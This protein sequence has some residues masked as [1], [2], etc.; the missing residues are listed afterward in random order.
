MAHPDEVSRR[1]AVAGAR[2]PGF[3]YGT[4]WKE[5]ETERLTR[6]AL[7]A[8]F[9]GIDTANQRR[10]Y[11]EAGVGAALAGA[12]A[13]GL[14]R[15]EELFVQTKFTSVA[16]QDHRLPYDPRADA[17]TQVRQSFASSLEHL[18][19]ETLDSYVLH[20]PARR[21]GLTALDLEVWQAMEELSAA[22]RTRFLGVSN[23]GLDQL[24]ELCARAT[25][26]P[27]FV[28]NRCFARSGWDREV[29]AFC[30]ER[31]IVYQGFSLLTANL[32][33]LRHPAFQ[34]V[35]ARVGKTP[36]QVVF[37]FALQVG[38]QPLTGT[39]DPRHM[40]EDLESYEFA[41]SPEDVRLVEGIAGA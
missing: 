34:H 21:S 6:L 31:G 11:H 4:A 28:Q 8:G 9:R 39:T 23:V 5:A 36:A 22:G 24:E 41:L 37:R 2:V 38:M 32:A 25:T 18:R 27:A 15:R 19:I 40:R 26:P 16:G 3:V 1:I 29:R 14:V 13:A 7:E 35:V 33:E 17:G 20:G 10:H 30:R 12:I